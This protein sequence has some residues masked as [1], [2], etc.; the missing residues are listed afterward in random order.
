VALGCG[1][2]EVKAK[3]VLPVDLLTG[4]CHGARIA[5]RFR[6]E[7]SLWLPGQSSLKGSSNA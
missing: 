5:R 4:E 3:A 7:E 6:H 1:S 2:D